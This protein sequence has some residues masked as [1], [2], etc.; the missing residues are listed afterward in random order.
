MTTRVSKWQ[1]AV[2]L[3]GCMLTAVPLAAQT[4]VGSVASLVGT[5]EV[6][7]AGKKTWQAIFVGAPVLLGDTLRTAPDAN[8]RIVLRDDTVIDLGSD[9]RIKVERLVV[10]AETQNQ[11][12]L[13]RMT[14]GQA[15]VLLGMREGA[16]RGRVEVETSTAVAGGRTAAFI[17]RF[18]EKGQHTDV[19]GLEGT[20]EVQGKL[21]VLEEAAQV[22]PRQWTRVAKGRLPSPPEALNEERFASYVSGLDI[23]GTGNRETL[24]V[25]HPALAGRLLRPADRPAIAPPP[26]VA[27]AAAPAERESYLHPG[28]PGET[29]VQQRSKDLSVVY[30]P[31]LE[32]QRSDP[33]IRPPE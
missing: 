18:D 8:A 27:A 7:R 28:V 19:V 5:L 16:E 20:T 31:I 23:V 9:T 12:A 24:D 1:I 6:Q 4:E 32:F 13:I 3:A 10:E 22:G 30:Q 17:L 2:L 21:G 33:D 25:G 14:S 11:R 26:A 15:R 29:F